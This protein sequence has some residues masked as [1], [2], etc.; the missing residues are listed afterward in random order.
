MKTKITKEPQWPVMSNANRW[1][2][3]YIAIPLI[4][5]SLILNLGGCAAVKSV[6]AN[7][8]SPTA[9]QAIANLKAGAT[10]AICDIAAG[11]ALAGQIETAIN[12]GQSTQGTN[13]KVLTVSTSVCTALQGTSSG[14]TVATSGTP[15]VTGVVASGV[16]TATVK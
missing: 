16:T 1:A 10:V 3:T 11:S 8:G 14:T 15:V 2:L 6:E 7:L 12:A 13:L 4:A 9:T 5:Y